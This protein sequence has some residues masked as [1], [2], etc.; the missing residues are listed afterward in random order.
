MENVVELARH[1]HNRTSWGSG[2]LKQI[3]KPLAWSLLRN[4]DAAMFLT[5]R[6]TTV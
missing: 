5:W 1:V 2:R 6:G 3:P 4:R